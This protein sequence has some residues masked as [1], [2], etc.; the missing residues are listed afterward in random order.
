MADV[1]LAG[2]AAGEKENPEA[3]AEATPAPGRVL[4]SLA[5]KG[6]RGDD[7]SPIGR[8][9]LEI[10]EADIAGASNSLA[11][12]RIG[13]LMLPGDQ[14]LNRAAVSFLI[15]GDEAILS[16]ILLDSATLGLGGSGR[17][18]LSDFSIAARLLPK[19]RLGPISDLVSAISGTVYAVDI[20][21]PLTDPEVRLT[22]LPLMVSAPEIAPDSDHENQPQE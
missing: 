9:E 12:L 19:G 8:G 21:G 5:L 18:R 6:V 13:Q 3:A 14:G 1:R 22:P 11:L 2:L 7:L 17:L 20:Q 15:D 10:R 16:R 4:A